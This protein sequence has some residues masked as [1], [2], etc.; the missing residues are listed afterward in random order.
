MQK[1]LQLSPKL[2]IVAHRN[3]LKR[4]AMEIKL[5][6]YHKKVNAEMRAKV[7][8]QHRSRDSNLLA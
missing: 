4:R 2:P 7:T 1:S 5:N 6:D 8:D 3:K